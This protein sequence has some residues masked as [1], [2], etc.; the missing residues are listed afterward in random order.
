M[1]KLSEITGVNLSENLGSVQGLE[2]YSEEEL[3]QMV[4]EKTDEVEADL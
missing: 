4:R 1:K 2:N 3:I